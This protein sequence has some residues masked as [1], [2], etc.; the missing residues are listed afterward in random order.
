MLNSLAYD[1]QIDLLASDTND[2]NLM[3]SLVS[4]I[5]NIFYFKNH[6]NFS[7]LRKLF[8]YIKTCILT[9]LFLYPEHYHTIS[10]LSLRKKLKALIR[11]NNYD[12]ILLHYWWLHKMLPKNLG[13]VKV[14][15]DTHG[16]LFEKVLL[17]ANLQN[18]FYR[19]IKE[20][21]Y[22]AIYKKKEISSLNR[23]DLLVF[24][25]EQDKI[26]Y[27]TELSG[28]VNS[29]TISNGQDLNYFNSEN[30]AKAENTILFY[31]SLGGIQNQVAFERFWNNIYPLIQKENNKIKLIVLGN[32][33][34]KWI[35]E[36]ENDNIVITGFVEDIRP[37]IAQC[38]VCIL[39]LSIGAGFRGRVV[40]VMAL[41][42]PVVG[43]HNALDNLNM[44]S[45]VHGYISDDN[46]ELANY[47]LEL[48][49]NK[50]LNLEMSANCIMFIQNNF[51][52]ENTYIRLSKFISSLNC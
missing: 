43:T 45:G 20:A 19:R 1:H 39:P 42:V 29:I 47:I 49:K 5:N 25:S 46:K 17:E 7:L 9:C 18:G 23:S 16:L 41:G 28:K 22:A 13:N 30:Y 4:N 48:L 10:N 40:E 31:G 38:N 27:L 37:Y 6:K 50:N 33:P 44:I 3:L 34:P 12:I 8:F 21:M 35:R 26:K 51:S 2:K 36:L 15:I 52:I 32:N 14:I 11:Q 24:N